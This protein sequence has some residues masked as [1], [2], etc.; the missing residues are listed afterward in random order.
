MNFA[1]NREAGARRANAGLQCSDKVGASVL[2]TTLGA[3]VAGG[4]LLAAAPAFAQGGCSRDAR[5][6]AAEN[7]VAAQTAGDPF[8]MH[9]GLWVDYNEQLQ[10]GSMSSRRDVSMQWS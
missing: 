10:N 9:M 6:S 7:Y 1:R 2:A 4:L 5:Q 8:K 3:I